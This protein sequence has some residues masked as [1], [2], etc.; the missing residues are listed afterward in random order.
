[1]LGPAQGTRC[2]P[3]LLKGREL[4][5][6]WTR[7]FWSSRRRGNHCACAVCWKFGSHVACRSTTRTLCSQAILCGL[8]QCTACRWVTSAA[9]CF[10]LNFLVQ[11]TPRG[12]TTHLPAGVVREIEAVLIV[13]RL[14][15][16]RRRLL[17]EQAEAAMS[18]EPTAVTADQAAT[19]ATAVAAAGAAV[20]AAGAVPSARRASQGDAAG[21]GAVA[22]RRRSQAAGDNAGRRLT[23]LLEQQQERR[24]SGAIVAGDGGSDDEGGDATPRARWGSVTFGFQD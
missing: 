15:P 9:M 12:T 7:G 4:E 3:L 10:L 20:E 22:P 19:G 1:M 14:W 6:Y 11:N 24:R 16:S 17:I 8:F 23:Q 18:G 21:A 13:A 2:G 5:N